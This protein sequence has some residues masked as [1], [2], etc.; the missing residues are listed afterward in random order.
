MKVEDEVFRAVAHPV[1][2]EMLELLA[3]SPRSVGELTARFA[4]S[5]PAVSQHLKE[6]REAGLVE[7]EQVG[8]T[9]RYRLRAGPLRQ[10]LDWAEPFRVL[11][12]SAGH[13]WT[14]VASNPSEKS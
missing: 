12:D 1:R 4:M 7:W 8:Q 2:R 10:V 13:A 6:L 11:L 5:Q 3:D 14:F 9:R